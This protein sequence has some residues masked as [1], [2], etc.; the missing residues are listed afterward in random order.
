MRRK[1]QVLG[2][3]LIWSAVLIFGYL[4]WQLFG[5]D[6]LNAGVQAEAQDALA[7]S[8]PGRATE[9]TEEVDVS[10]YLGD[11]DPAEPLP[12]Q[13]EFH[14]EE[15]SEPGEELAFIRIAD[16]ELEAVLFEGVDT[17]TLR[18]GPGH[19]PGTPIPGQPGNAVV[20]G[21]R[22]TYGR[23]FF[24]LDLLAI[25]DQIEVET[26][27]GTHLYEVRETVIVQPNDVW[28]TD[29]R[30]GGW[31]TLTTC[32]PKFSARERLV[33]W[34]EMVSGPNLEFVEL[35]KQRFG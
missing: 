5:T 29:P 7:A 33:V 23:P 4:G 32:N 35:H 8:L 21:H 20:S 1:I 27:I 17:E 13:V 26:A 10:E 14:P 24:D 11:E 12:D 6:L 28:V 30:P 9:P 15:A 2:W 31:L 16:I 34:A 19:M 22:T 3:T 25:G 18:K